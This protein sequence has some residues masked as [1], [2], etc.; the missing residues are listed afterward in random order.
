[1]SG[2]AGQP[3]FTFHGNAPGGLASDAIASHSACF[4]RQRRSMLLSYS[5]EPPALDGM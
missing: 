5:S 3:L 2:N 4:K 1:M